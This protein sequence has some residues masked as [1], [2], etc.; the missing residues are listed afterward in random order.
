MNKFLNLFEK[1]IVTVLI[2]IMVLVIIFATLVLGSL[3]LA[4]VLS[5]PN[6]LLDD[7]QLLDVLGYVM[8]IIIGIELLETVKLYLKEHV[9]HVEVVLEVA[10]TAVARKV[11]LL[12]YKEYS[13]LTV[14]AIA[15]LI[16]ALS[17]GYFLVRRGRG[18]AP[19]LTSENH[20]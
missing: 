20:P 16:L 11:I 3:L 13:A 9:F 7:I 18:P 15:S 19:A 5:S 8:L 14:L 10:M 2:L 17:I 12:D 4:Y 6:Y 1:V